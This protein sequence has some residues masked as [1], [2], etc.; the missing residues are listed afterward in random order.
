MA[1]DRHHDSAICHLAT[2]L[3][4]RMA[5]CMRTGQPYALRDV[6]GSPITEADR[7][8]RSR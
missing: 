2:L 8:H 5:T 4:T 6:D 1:G 3:V 7:S